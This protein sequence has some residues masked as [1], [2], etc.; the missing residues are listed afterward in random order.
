MTKIKLTNQNSKDVTAYITLGATTGCVVDV[1]KIIFSEE[2]ELT[3]VSKLMGHF[4]LKGNTSLYLSAPNGEG[5]NG[6]ISFN[7]PPMNCKSTDLPNGMNVA[8]FIVNNGFQGINSQETIDN[9]CVAGANAKIK[10]SMDADDWATNSGNIKVSEFENN[11]WDKNTDIIGVFPYG[12]DN[13]TASVSPPDCVGKQPQYASSTPIC[14]VQRSAE[15]N[16]G[17]TLEITF[18]EFL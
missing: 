2:V 1:T 14:N 15:N 8:E 4:T 12:C 18:I 16:K 11:A 5:F 3:K 17:G 10:F 6:N 7:T 9:S 13:C